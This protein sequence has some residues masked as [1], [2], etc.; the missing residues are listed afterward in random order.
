LDAL[1][2]ADGD[3]SVRAV[4]DGSYRASPEAAAVLFRRLGAHPG[5]YFT[6]ETGVVLSG[7]PRAQARDSFETLVR[8][9]LLE[10]IDANRFAAQDLL[11][12]Y[13]VDLI[14]STET[15][16]KIWAPRTGA[17]VTG[18]ARPSRSTRPASRGRHGHGHDTESEVLARLTAAHTSPT[19]GSRP[20]AVD[21]LRGREREQ[22][23]Q[24]VPE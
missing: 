10:R 24:P 20:R 15:H 6:V 22:L 9:H 19:A 16:S 1:R 18:A 12:A 11:R 5:E 7:L 14:R 2:E 3:V 21:C 23:G 4:F 8:A 13:A 17:S